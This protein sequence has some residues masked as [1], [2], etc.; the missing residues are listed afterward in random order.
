MRL[1]VCLCVCG[2]VSMY[3]NMRLFYFYKRISYVLT[4]FAPAVSKA[5]AFFLSYEK[6][7]NVVCNNLSLLTV[8]RVRS[9]GREKRSIQ[10]DVV[11]DYHNATENVGMRYD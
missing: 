10:Y 7:M 6:E 2:F 3:V 5:S 1:Q 9:F 4:W 11:M 8:F